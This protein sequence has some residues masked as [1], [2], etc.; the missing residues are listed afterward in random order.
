MNN[1]G[2][3]CIRLQ[4]NAANRLS[5]NPQHFRANDVG[6]CWVRLQ[7]QLYISEFIK[8]Q[9]FAQFTIPKATFIE[10][11]IHLVITDKKKHLNVLQTSLSR[12][13]FFITLIWSPVGA[14][15]IVSSYRD[16]T[17]TRRQ[18]IREIDFFIYLIP[19]ISLK[20]FL[21]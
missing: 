1:N 6:S 21:N 7:V 9:E 13:Q 16:E 4:T 10:L 5:N 14:I 19:H 11:A 18:P 3:Y 17:K 8:G 2:S 12:N 20:G 15:Q